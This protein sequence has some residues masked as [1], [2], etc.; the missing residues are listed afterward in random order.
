MTLWALD[1]ECEDWD[2]LVLGAACSSD[3]RVVRFD[4]RSNPE[5]QLADWY[6]GVEANDLIIAHNGGRYDFLCL[7]GAMPSERWTGTLAGSALVSLKARGHA[8]LRDSFR[9]VMQSLR[10][11]TGAKDDLGLPCLCGEGCGGYCS[12]HRK[13]TQRAFDRV[14]DYC[15]QDCRALLSAYVRTVAMAEHDGFAM[16]D[17]NGNIR[18]TCGAVAW[19]TAVAQCPELER[20][21][22]PED[23][24]EYDECMV[25]AYG[26]RVGCQ[27]TAW[28]P[29]SQG[30]DE[31]SMYPY[32]LTK[33]VP[34]GRPSYLH[35]APDAARA[36]AAGR[37][38]I[39]TC[40]VR[41][42][43]GPFALLPHRGREDDMV[44]STGTIEGSWTTIEL[45]AAERY[46]ASIDVQSAVVWRREQAIYEPFMRWGWAL[47][48][49]ARARGDESYREFIKRIINSFTG[50]TGQGGDA[51]TFHI[52]DER[53]DEPR[54]GW[55]YLGGRDWWSAWQSTHRRI[56]DC[57]R[58]HHYAWLTSRGRVDMLDVLMLLGRDALYWDTDGVKCKRR[59]P[60]HLVGGDLGQWKHEG[61]LS[62]WRCLAPKV[63]RYLTE[64]GDWVTKAK[65]IPRAHSG[66]FSALASGLT[67]VKEVGVEGVRS[68]F[69]GGANPF[70]KRRVSR[71]IRR[72]RRLCGTRYVEPDGSTTELHREPDGSYR[73]PG[74]SADVGAL[75]PHLS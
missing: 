38:G 9:L 37:P 30:Y 25:A 66:N 40:E 3:R 63:Y 50:K 60:A 7:L 45:E 64:G 72:D 74:H 68:A 17:R 67:V 58:P 61:A 34:V 35:R 26:G 15:I 52:V 20:E 8:E 41:M 28:E 36:L 18:R 47:R 10:D 1:I 21:P 16:R 13:M 43:E 4:S 19:H 2:Q 32:Q 51:E 57:S 31:N 23:W 75:L 42:P 49:A 6:A 46:G 71:G 29:V 56:P 27:W 69:K 73:W 55:R 59:L 53:E 54:E 24:E 39:Y 33:P 11:W 48:D 62:M 65:G 12:I 14:M 5:R 70:R 44:W 22:P